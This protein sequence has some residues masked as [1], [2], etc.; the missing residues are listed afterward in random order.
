[1]QEEMRFNLTQI[2]G[3][4]NSD[5]IKRK[6]EKVVSDAENINKE[7]KDS[8]GNISPKKILALLDRY[9]SLI[10]EYDDYALY[11]ILFHLTDSLNQDAQTLYNTLNIIRSE[12][13]KLLVF[14]ETE[15][16]HALNKNSKL[17]TNPKLTRYRHHLERIESRTPYRLSEAE[18]RLNSLKNRT[19]VVAWSQLQSDWI[20]NQ[21]WRFKYKGEEKNI[22]Y[23]EYSQTLAGHPDRA[24]RMEATK[25]VCRGLEDCS[26]IWAPA[27]YNIIADHVAMYKTRGHPS[28]LTE[29]L[30]MND[31]PEDA[32]NSLNTAVKANLDV[33]HRYLR[34]K[35]KLMGLRKLFEW[36]L[37]ANIPKANTRNLTWEE[38]RSLIFEAYNDFDES[39][40]KLAD[41]SFKLR[42]ID[43]ETRTGKNAYGR[44]LSWSRGGTGFVI[45][46]FRGSM[47][48]VSILAHELGHANHYRMMRDLSPIY[49][50]SN[51]FLR[52]P[53]MCM[54]ECGSLFGELLLYDKLVGDSSDPLVRREVLCLALDSFNDNVFG[55]LTMFEHQKSLYKAVD[56]GN[57]LGG[58]EMCAFWCNVRD[59]FY[60]DNVEYPDYLRWSWAGMPHYY[61]WDLQFYSYPYVFGELLGYSLYSLYKKEGKRFASKLASLL[62]KGSSIS[63]AESLKE[64]G[65]DIESKNFWE[66][67]FTQVK[68]YLDQ[69][70]AT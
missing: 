53:S 22:N 6:L 5:L 8:S 43:A 25:A 42:R 54:M 1:M 57:S 55:A 38:A 64:L 7:F 62:S 68:S 10:K 31:V 39:W 35:A 50:P 26:Q 66:M 61:R 52:Y 17:I 48:D 44:C 58:E 30:L 2:V 14:M 18:E 40:G 51:L 29:S 70:K 63:P 49:K 27:L 60:G 12:A 46:D 36:D 34:L 11:A 13:S 56:E 41:E 67:G 28:Y 47:R 37:Y 69:I 23:S 32:L 3:T 15:I 21:R 20:S 59:S 65:F 4:D 16:S 9:C 19:G 33:I 24:Y 45:G